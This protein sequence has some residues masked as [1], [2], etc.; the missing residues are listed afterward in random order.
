MEDGRGVGGGGGRNRKDGT[1]RT[2][3]GRGARCTIGM[4]WPPARLRSTHRVAKVKLSVMDGI[5]KCSGE[6]TQEEQSPRF[7]GVVSSLGV[8]SP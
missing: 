6:R 1:L 5:E 3:A 7:A 4:W 2:H 8:A